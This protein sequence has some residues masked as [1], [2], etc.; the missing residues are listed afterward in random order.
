MCG[1]F[2]YHG[3]LCNLKQLMD[4]IKTIQ[5]RGPDDTVMKYVG[6]DMLFAFHRLAI[7]D[8]TPKGSQPMSFDNGNLSFMCNGEIYNWKKLAKD[9]KFE[10]ESNCD[11]EIIYHLYKKYGF[12]ETIKQLDG[13]FAITLYDSN[14]DTLFIARDPFGVRPLFVGTIG[15]EY[16]FAS[17]M[18]ALTAVEKLCNISMHIEQFPPGNI[19][20]I[21]NSNPICELTSYFEYTPY[22][23]ETKHL[24]HSDIEEVKVN[25][26]SLFVEAVGKRIYSDRPAGALLSGGLDSSLVASLA[27]KYMRVQYENGIPEWDSR[28]STLNL[29]LKKKPEEFPIDKQ[30]YGSD[31]DKSKKEEIPV[32]KFK[33]FSIGLSGS[34]DIKY[35]NI[36]RLH[37][38]SDHYQEIKSD[39]DCLRAIEETIY[40]IESYDVTTVR[41]SI[42]NYLLCKG[43]GGN[44]DCKVLFNGDGSDEIF[45][46]Y[47]YF[48]KCTDPYEFNR[49]N[50]K[51]M[52]NIHFFDILRSDRSISSNGIEARSPFM[53]IAFVKYCMMIDPKLKMSHDKLEKYILREAF[54][55]TDILPMEI[56]FREKEAFSDGVSNEKRSWH[57]TI[58][59]FIDRIITD[60][61]FNENATQYKYNTPLT[62]EAYFYRNLFE[63]YYPNHATVLPYCW[64][65]N[66]THTTDPSARELETN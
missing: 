50:I 29:P 62:K 46:G 54:K 28:K 40:K 13:Y 52:K 27:C 24:F 20:I 61:N 19:G 21:N 22:T 14:I 5:H 10:L 58:Q 60:E 42:Y 26:C 63:K 9:N 47:K 49:E 2:V 41:A 45:G 51:L 59:T 48:K 36:M 15:N 43:I 65:P 31:L 38:G 64:M 44:V 23:D 25:I 57:K 12:E 30:V 7:M 34:P 55:T 11:C 33:T 66:W 35:A 3:K 56:L 37:I 32:F 53:D 4:C 17:E 16:Y 1:I 8:P 39:S 6:P 18:K